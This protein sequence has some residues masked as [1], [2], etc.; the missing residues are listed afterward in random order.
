MEGLFKDFQKFEHLIGYFACVNI[1]G[2]FVSK[3]TSDTY[4]LITP[5]GNIS[6]SREKDKRNSFVLL[7]SILLKFTCIIQD[8]AQHRGTTISSDPIVLSPASTKLYLICPSFIPGTTFNFSEQ[9]GAK[10]DWNER[11]RYINMTQ[12][13]T[14]FTCFSSYSLPVSLPLSLCIYF[15]IRTYPRVN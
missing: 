7:H 12:D 15:I 10:F 2:W 3:L 13:I 5:K 11:M 8:N 1:N 6:R 4:H 14:P 9:T